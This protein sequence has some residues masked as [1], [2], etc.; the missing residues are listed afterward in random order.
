MP[1]PAFDNHGDLPV[2]VH[3]ATLAEV[4]GRF[5]YGMPQR[6]LVTA[7]LIHIYELT[8]RTGKLLRF[9]IF[10]SYVTDK[11]EPNDIDILLVMTDDFDVPACDEQTQPLFDHLRGQAIFGA[12]VFSIRPSTAFRV[13][14]DEF[15][16]DWQIKRD[17]SRH[18]IVEVIPEKT[19]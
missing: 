2:G 6:E 5:G 14:V 10:G 19:P 7:R 11:P 12:S 16:A 8:R 1:L 17:Q 4:I 15:I 13:S 18:G 3:L 9:V